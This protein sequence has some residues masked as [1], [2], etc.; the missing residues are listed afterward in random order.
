[1]GRS[2]VKSVGLEITENG[3]EPSFAPLSVCVGLISLV[4]IGAVGCAIATGTTPQLSKATQGTT[5]C[6]FMFFN[7]E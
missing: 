2:G 7:K 1:M 3:R 6:T 4:S 5:R